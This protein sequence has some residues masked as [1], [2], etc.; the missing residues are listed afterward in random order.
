MELDESGDDYE[1]DKDAPPTTAAEDAELLK[2]CEEAIEEE[3][4]LSGK[5]AK[6][7]QWNADGNKSAGK[8]ATL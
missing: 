5:E 4:T 7:Q 8:E 3:P 1:A 6:L 2:E